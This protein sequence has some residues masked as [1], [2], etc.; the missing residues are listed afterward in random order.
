MLDGHGY[1]HGEQAKERGELDHGIERHRTGVFERVTNRVA[2]DRGGMKRRS[3]HFQIHLHDFLG[4][5]P[6]ATGIGHEN[7]LEQAEERDG[8][9]IA[10]EKVGVEKCQRKR[11]AENH[12]EDVPHAFL[13]VH[14]ANADDF[15]AVGFRGS[16]GIQL[17]VV[18]N[19]NHGAIGPGDHRLGA[20]PGKPIDHRAPHEQAQNNLR[21]HDAQGFNH[22][23]ER[24]R[25]AGS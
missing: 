17:H 20:G 13:G 24:A 18:L 16:G 1:F 9:E 19:V 5:V 4:V 14:C 21:L 22:W 15:F 6:G 11:E 7:C 12:N 25:Q 23:L 3:F 10:D 2:H 8:D